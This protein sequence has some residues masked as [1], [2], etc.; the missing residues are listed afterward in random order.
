M[1]SELSKREPWGGGG[2]PTLVGIDSRWLRDG[3]REVD[4]GALAGVLVAR[5]VVELDRRAGEGTLRRS[6]GHLGVDR[7]DGARQREVALVA[8]PRRR[9]GGLGDRGDARRYA[10]D[11]DRPGVRI[12]EIARDRLSAVTRV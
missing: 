9:A 2:R 3:V 10:G 7:H 5:L 6:G 4:R 11:L 8:R 1:H 12:V